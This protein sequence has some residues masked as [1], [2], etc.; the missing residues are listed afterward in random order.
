M[1]NK[2]LFPVGKIDLWK[3]E[4]E[5]VKDEIEIDLFD[6]QEEEKR[7]EEYEIQ[8]PADDIRDVAESE[9]GA[10]I[11]EANELSSNSGVQNSIPAAAGTPDVN[12][13]E[14][15]A[16][17][18][19]GIQFVPTAQRMQNI[20]NA[21]MPVGKRVNFKTIFLKGILYGLIGGLVGWGLNEIIN[22]QPETVLKWM[23]YPGGI[24][25]LL[26]LSESHAMSLINSALRTSTAAFSGIIG[27]FIGSLLGLGEGIYYGS[28][29][30]A[31]RY[32]FIG[33]GISLVIGFI[34]GYIAQ[35]IY[36]GLLKDIE[37]V[38]LYA[39][40]IRAIA[41]A[42][43]GLGVGISV[44]LIKPEV[45]RLI[46]CAIGGLAGGF[47]GGFAFNYIYNIAAFNENDT[48]VIP[49]AIGIIFMGLLIGLGIGLLEQF[50]KSAWLKVIRGEFEGKEYLV[51][52]GTTSIGNSGKNTI[53]LFKDKLV[54]PYH[55]EIVLEGSKYV[56]IDKGSPMGTIVNGMRVNRH[57]LRQGDAIAIGNS[58][59]VF[60]TK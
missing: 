57:I 24:A 27:G 40:F 38:G 39:S 55:C 23:G 10:A 54:A 2:H 29:E 58:V 20:S 9:Q 50:A 46:N 41:W 59:L 15:T 34:G 21:N 18:L 45:K 52:A 36:S 14:I 56:L 35:I 26:N 3:G 11:E 22:L 6:D 47:L 1:E 12:D 25:D 42:L 37:T 16:D 4:A 5:G 60:N 17:E 44:G 7:L 32:T 49:R 53:V 19:A 43:M 13:F 8:Q 33:L 28:K 30:K 48:G 51:F 31:V